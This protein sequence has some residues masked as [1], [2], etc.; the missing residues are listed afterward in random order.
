MGGRVYGRAARQRARCFNTSCLPEG[1]VTERTASI[2]VPPRPATAGSAAWIYELHVG[3]SAMGRAAPPRRSARAACWPDR[4]PCP[5]LRSLGVTPWSCSAG[6]GLRSTRMHPPARQQ[7]LGLHSPL[8]WMAPPS[9]AICVG[10]DPLEARQAGARPRHRLS[11]GGPVKLLLDVVYNTPAEGTRT[12][13]NPQLAQGLCRR[14]LFTSRTSRAEYQESPLRQTRSRPTGRWCGSWIS[15]SDA[16]WALED[17]HVASA[18]I[19]ASPSPAAKNM[20]AAG[21]AP[22]FGRSKPTGGSAT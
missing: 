4:T 8:S 2:F 15:E 21:S 3:G 12:G 14:P 10:N 1:V 19:W 7:L 6:D 5:Y 17:G 9:G 13:S 20:L 18:S 16:R 11:P 22:L